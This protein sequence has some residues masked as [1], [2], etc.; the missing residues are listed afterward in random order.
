M[1]K[2]PFKECQYCKHKEWCTNHKPMCDERDLCTSDDCDK[3][4]NH[5]DCWGYQLEWERTNE[6]EEL[7][8]E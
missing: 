1:K 2:T 7:N 8:N 5:F 4:D 6:V 3:C